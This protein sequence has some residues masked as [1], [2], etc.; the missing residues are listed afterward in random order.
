MTLSPEFP[1]RAYMASDIFFCI[2]MLNIL[3]QGKINV[4]EVVKK[5][6]PTAALIIFVFFCSS[7]LFA[8]RNVVGVYAKWQMRSEYFLEQKAKGNTNVTV[9]VPIP[10]VNKHVALY[11]LKDLSIDPDAWFNKSTA[12]YFEL[13][14]IRGFE[15]DEPW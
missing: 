4:P 7:F 11:G 8:C 9:K 2:A 6:I 14:S 13:D 12:A 15:N 1:D 3:R 5:N 10:V